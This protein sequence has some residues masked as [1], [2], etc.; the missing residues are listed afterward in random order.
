[1]NLDFTEEQEMLRTTARNFLKA[2]CPKSV[3]RQLEESDLGYSPEIWKKM[4]VLGWQG[5]AFP[6][7]HGGT[8]MTFFE[9]ALVM[10]QIG[11]N[12]LPGPFLSTV[13]CGLSILEE[14]TVAQKKEFLPKL[15]AGDMI[16]AYAYTEPSA[17]WKA[18]DISARAVAS[19]GNYVINGTKLFVA[20]A[21]LADFLL[22]VTKTGE[23]ANPEENITVFVVDAK[24]PGIQC[25][26][27]LTM[28]LDNKCEVRFKDVIVTKNNMLG[29]L[30]QG[31]KVV[32][33]VMMK[34]ATAKVA[35]M[36][37]GC[38]AAMEMANN[39]AKERVQYG[40][41]IG[42]FQVIQHYLADMWSYADRTRNIAWEV[43]WK[44]GTGAAT[45][46]DVAIAK[47]WANEAYKWI[48]ERALHIHGAIGLTRDHDIGLYYRR[49]KVAELEYGDTD[50][51]RDIVSR[52]LG[53]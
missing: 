4:S 42:N 34:G 9:L 37:G 33:S 30:N 1:M 6:E 15:A 18:A 27:Q 26:P 23:S 19:D 40:R 49:A 31:W 45:P 16:L 21:H 53:L 44:V 47:S 41:P 20:D 7:K 12:I 46:L 5:L 2:E 24:S 35:E 8:G 11:Y 25:E 51:Q 48:T 50:Y 29:A 43:A 14:G 28:G 38:Q 10:E 36:S 17:S 32:N 22:V 13:V 52:E 39:Y 3:V